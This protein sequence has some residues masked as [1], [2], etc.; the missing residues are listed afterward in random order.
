MT[1]RI[2]GKQ[3]TFSQFMQQLPEQEGRYELVNGNIHPILLTRYQ[4]NIADFVA[5]KFDKE[6]ERWKLNYRV[7]GRI[8]IR[9]FTA[10][11]REQSRQPDISVVDQ[12]KWTQHPYAYAALLEPIQLAVE[13]IN[14]LQDD[15]IHKYN[16]YERLGIPEY[17]L[18]DPLGLVQHHLD[19]PKIP[20]VFVNLLDNNGIYQSQTYHGK[21][22]IVSE[23]FPQLKLSVEQILQA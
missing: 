8:M 1:L 12:T 6:V 2:P 10:T 5:R 21:E 15:Y 4:I 22:P 14:N 11:G 16:E 3:L 23:T 19:R 20:Q 13:V 17:W 18:V 9:T 7:S